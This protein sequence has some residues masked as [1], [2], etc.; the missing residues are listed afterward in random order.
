[1]K[2]NHIPF[3]P[4]IRKRLSTGGHYHATET[5]LNQW[6]I[7]T[8][9][10]QA[11]CPNQH[12]CWAKGTATVLI[13]GNICTRNCP[14]CSVSHGNPAPA[15]PQEPKRIAELAYQLGIHYLVITSVDRD[16]LPDGGVAQF[17]NVV[18]AC[19]EKDPSM[20]F[21]L[22]VPDFK[23]VQEN[24]LVLLDD[25]QPF[26]FGHNVE[27]VPELYPTVRP[28][29]SYVRSLQLL[30]KAKHRWP[31]SQTKSSMM[32][33]LGETDD[34]IRRV[35]KDLRDCGCDR[36]CLGQYL[37]PSKNALEVKQFVHPEQFARWAEEAKA[38]GFSWVISEPFARSSYHAEEDSPS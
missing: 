14:F 7:D 27:T 26:V 38:M 34:Q 30:E 18:S 29:G 22:L 1:M 19:R 32:L 16:D 3:P 12:E 13:L 20:R 8:I 9:C 31:E 10:Q 35:L 21:E 28:G 17:C 37:K 33:G 2:P 24:A 23:N 6:G 15:D 5:S 11:H 4:W 25:I 36:L